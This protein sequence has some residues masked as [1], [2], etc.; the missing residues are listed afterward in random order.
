M[1]NICKYVSHASGCVIVMCCCC[2][3]FLEK[4]VSTRKNC[5][6]KKNTFPLEYNLCQYDLSSVCKICFCCWLLCV[7]PLDQWKITKTSSCY[8]CGWLRWCVHFPHLH[9]KLR[10]LRSE[11]LKRENVGLLRLVKVFFATKHVFFHVICYWIIF[12]KSKY[13]GW[14]CMIRELSYK[15]MKSEKSQTYYF[16]L[17]WLCILGKGILAEY[18][19]K[20]NTST[21]LASVVKYAEVPSTSS[22][23]CCLTATITSRRGW[24]GP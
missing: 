7:T 4:L 22:L 21:G 24:W 9:G 11:K 15:W 16:T 23:R 14:G 19:I 5:S 8:C 17:R 2:C 18:I 12:G 3:I 13:L 6:T 20:R 1:S 10:E